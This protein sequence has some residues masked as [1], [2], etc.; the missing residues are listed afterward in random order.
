VDEQAA[1]LEDLMKICDDRG[2]VISELMSIART[3][4]PRRTA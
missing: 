4:Y 1:R 2:R 3:A